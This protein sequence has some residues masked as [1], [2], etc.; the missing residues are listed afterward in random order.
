M[1]LVWVISLSNSLVPSLAFPF[2]FYVVWCWDQTQ[3]FE[4]G[5]QALSLVKHLAIIVKALCTC[6]CMCVRAC[7]LKVGSLIHSR[8]IFWNWM[9][10]LSSTGASFNVSKHYGF[11]FPLREKFTLESPPYFFSFFFFFSKRNPPS[12]PSWDV[13]IRGCGKAVTKL[14]PF[15]APHP[16]FLP[17]S[18]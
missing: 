16:L 18:C 12:F 10:P 9:T 7:V 13:L 5:R 14:T 17:C 1:A 11:F 2:A 3:V 6:V 4:C 15:H 8:H